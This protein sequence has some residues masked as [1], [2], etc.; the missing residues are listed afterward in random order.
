[1]P[2]AQP[3]NQTVV[4]QPPLP[5]A[6][7]TRMFREA[8]EACD[9]V[10][11]QLERLPDEFARLA[12]ELRTGRHAGIVTLARGSSDHAATY[13]KYLFESRLGILTASAAP[14]ISS[15]YKAR[16]HFR[17]TV[18]L[19]ISQ[20]GKSPDLLA[21]V[22]AAR[23][24]GACVVAMVNVEDS[25]L[26]GSAHFAIPLCAGEETS[27]A[28][29]K[30]FI[31]SLAAVAQL[32]AHWA[33]DTAM[34]A[35]LERLPG[36]LRQAWQLDWR[37]ALERLRDKDSLYVIGRGLGLGVAQE[38]ALKLKETCGMHA[39]AF[40]SAELRHGPMAIVRQGFPVFAFAQNDA[41]REGIA[42]VVRELRAHGAEVLSAG[43][44]D[45]HSTSLPSIGDDPAIQPLLHIQAFYRV[46]N[47]L[48]IARGYD[49]DRPRHLSKVTETL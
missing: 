9:V 7:S 31:A 46:A 17:D 22:D 2:P 41:T 44:D 30:S 42:A 3:G 36:R 35:A 34:R 21:A 48:A 6:E 20:S 39:E 29:T 18:L 16:S 43:L 37:V 5:V 40:S 25:P 38:A 14:S 49:P 27:V 28:A 45:P 32:E 13:A 23:R 10:R 4:S 19:V 15:L 26:A 11:R 33:G 47:A 12:R 8:I 24:S 1:M